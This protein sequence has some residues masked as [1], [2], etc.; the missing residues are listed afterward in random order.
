MLN[1]YYSRHLL[2]IYSQLIRVQLRSRCL[3]AMLG[4]MTGHVGQV[5]TAGPAQPQP[6]INHGLTLLMF[7]LYHHHRLSRPF[8]RP[9]QDPSPQVKVSNIVLW[10]IT[11]ATGHNPSYRYPEALVEHSTSC[12]QHPTLLRGLGWFSPVV[13]PY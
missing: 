1:V 5:G 13:G 12:Q 10:L 9:S 8:P 2:Y 11:C 6:S 7:V 4:T 3:S